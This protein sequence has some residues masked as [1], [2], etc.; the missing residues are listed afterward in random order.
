MKAITFKTTDDFREW[1]YATLILMESARLSTVG[2][3]GAF[4]SHR[5]LPITR[6][7]SRPGTRTRYDT[8]HCGCN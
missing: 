5:L 4:K 3:M 1:L 2:H 6:A 8:S 7:I